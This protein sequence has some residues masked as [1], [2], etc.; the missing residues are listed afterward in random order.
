MTRKRFIIAAAICAVLSLAAAAWALFSDSESGGSADLVSEGISLR[1]SGK[2]QEAIEKL[3][4]ALAADPAC[5]SAARELGMIYIELGDTDKAIETWRQA[6]ENTG[7]ARFTALIEA[8]TKREDSSVTDETDVSGT[9]PD[10]SAGDDTDVTINIE[11]FTYISKFTYKDYAEEYGEASVVKEDDLFYVTF[12]DLSAEL[13]F[14]AEEG[15]TAPEEASLPLSV[16]VNDLG[17]LFDSF[18]TQLSF[19]ELETMG[20][21]GL[22]IND[23]D[24]GYTVTFRYRGCAVSI[25]SDQD[26]N[27]KG[28][29]SA[30][31]VTIDDSDDSDGT[32]HFVIDV[33]LAPY[34]YHIDSDYVLEIARAEDVHSPDDS[35][36]DASDGIFYSAVVIDGVTEIDLQDGEYIVCVYPEDQPDNFKRYTWN[37][38]ENT[39]NSDLKLIVTEKVEEG[40]IMIVL[41]W[42]DTPQDIDGYLVGEGDFIYYWGKEGVHGRLDTDCRSGNGIETITITDSS[43]KFTYYVDNYSGEEAM[44]KNSGATV[45]IF[46]EDTKYPQVFRIPGSIIDVWEV[47][48]IEDGI[49]TEIGK[50]GEPICP[51]D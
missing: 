44:G 6:Y 14:P 27:I 31:A 23:T 26:G 5:E 18:E 46:T 33:I 10:K 35:H 39:T 20:L 4:E 1:E 7:S 12:E 15:E 29:N 13:I 8:Y 21:T 42:N 11:I 25:E 41:R 37:I 32:R 34:G 38:D 16:S 49:V 24:E 9:D 28:R 36:L 45:T 30:N 40:Q 3:E 2:T 48:T 22:K 17:L 47:F 50:E 19:Q 51:E 43:G